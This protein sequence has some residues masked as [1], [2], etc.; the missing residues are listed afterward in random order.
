MRR[1]FPKEIQVFM[2]VSVYK[3][4]ASPE[5]VDVVAGN[6]C[7]II[8]S[9][10]DRRKVII[11]IP[12]HT[13]IIINS[14][15][16]PLMRKMS[17][18]RQHQESQLLVNQLLSSLPHVSLPRGSLPLKT[19]PQESQP[20]GDLLQSQID[21]HHLDLTLQSLRLNNLILLEQS[22]LSKRS[23]HRVRMT[24]VRL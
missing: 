15:Q 5:Y 14:I 20:Q 21:I 16:K 9:A 10:I 6:C 23:Q 2:L 24:M 7:C 4:L 8:I 11:H 19:Q 12:F 13:N 17:H 22:R 3:L 1:L 18:I